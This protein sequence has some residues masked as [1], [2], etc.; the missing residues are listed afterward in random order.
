MPDS[1]LDDLPPLGT[2]P[3][4][5]EARPTDAWDSVASCSQETWAEEVLHSG[6]AVLLD[7]R[8]DLEFKSRCTYPRPCWEM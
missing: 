4:A 5:G 1:P 7:V 3:E 6:T 2:A 8:N